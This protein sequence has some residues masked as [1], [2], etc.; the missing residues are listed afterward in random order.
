MPENSPYDPRALD[1]SRVSRA[2]SLAREI[3]RHIQEESLPDGW[4]L[5]TKKDVRER[6]HVAAGTVNQALRLLEN[7]G[8][9]AARPGPGGGLFV[10]TPSPHI[11]LSHLI[12]G[13]SDGGTTVAD[14]LAVRTGLEPL[15]AEQA[16]RHHTDADLAELRELLQR[17]SNSVDS[18]RGFLEANWA[19][20]RRMVE[21]S[22]NPVL[23]AVYG[24]LMDYIEGHVE[25]V[26][27][28]AVFRSSENL[29]VHR[30]LVAAIASRDPASVE[31]AVRKH[32]P[33]TAWISGDEAAPD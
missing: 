8:L 33:S 11:R 20:H 3:E 31:E 21:I 24:T 29:D 10:S 16:R 9:I 22:P 25:N 32:T 18:P 5:G 15:V 14:C 4:R 19:L 28:D 13:F 17:M 30:A 23:R 6:F 1:D 12:L 7:R 2:E 27:P 26:A